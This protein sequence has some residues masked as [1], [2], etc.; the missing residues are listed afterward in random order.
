MAKTMTRTTSRYTGIRL[1]LR[2]VAYLNP[3]LAIVKKRRADKPSSVYERICLTSSNT[4]LAFIR[5]TKTESTKERHFSSTSGHL[6]LHLLGLEPENLTKPNPPKITLT[7]FHRN[8][9]KAGAYIFCSTFHDDFLQ[10]R[11]SA[12][13]G[14]SFVHAARTFLFASL[15][16]ST[17]LQKEH[18][19]FIKI[20]T[21]NQV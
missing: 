8:P 11:P 21:I 12:V 4:T 3:A 16:Q 19:I 17:F 6:R 2:R 13:S 14:K 7:K 9:A 1:L 18:L 20:L 5:R 15:L 10:N